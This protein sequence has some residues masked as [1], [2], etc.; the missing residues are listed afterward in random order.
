M[1]IRSHSLSQSFTQAQVRVIQIVIARSYR[2]FKE[3]Q[4]LNSQKSKIRISLPW[5]AVPIQLSGSFTEPPW[6][7][8]QSLW[9]S[10]TSNDLFVTLWL[11]SGDTFQLKKRDEVLLHPDFPVV[12]VRTR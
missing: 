12:L 8:C 1:A 5:E 6:N 4:H 3:K 11:R 2:N 10:L 9:Y 7:V